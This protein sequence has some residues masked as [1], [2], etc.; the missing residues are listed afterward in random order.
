MPVGIDVE[1]DQDVFVRGGDL[2]PDF[3]RRRDCIR[4][5]RVEARVQAVGLVVR[6]RSQHALSLAAAAARRLQTQAPV[7]EALKQGAGLV[8]DHIQYFVVGQ[9]LDAASRGLG[10]QRVGG[11]VHVGVVVRRRQ[12]VAPGQLLQS[13]AFVA[14][15]E[16]CQACDVVDAGRDADRL[17]ER[18]PLRRVLAAGGANGG[19]AGSDENQVRC[20]ERFDQRFILRHETVAR[21]HR[22]VAVL[23][24]DTDDLGDT[25]LAFRAVRA[26]V[27]G[28][29][30]HR[31]PIP[32]GS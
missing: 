14:L 22:V 31:L 19:G 15:G 3:S 9:Q 8:T 32:D 26:R 1:F 11:Q 2:Y 6:R 7:G 16:Q 5:Y 30:V 4:R 25:R 18:R 24:G 20:F 12:A 23:S 21:E 13:G 28:N 27:I 10:Q 29:P 17:R